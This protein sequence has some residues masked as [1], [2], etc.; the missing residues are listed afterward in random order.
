MWL[1][2]DV[3]HIDTANM[4]PCA[5]VFFSDRPLL[6]SLLPSLRGSVDSPVDCDW[7]LRGQAAYHSHHLVPV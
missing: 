3:N 7:L 6:L 2:H 5:K 1:M 4:L